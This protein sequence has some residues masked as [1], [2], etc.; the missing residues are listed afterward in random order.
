MTLS[1]ICM[2]LPIK[3]NLDESETLRLFPDGVAALGFG[4]LSL[5]RDGLHINVKWNPAVYNII[6]CGR[7][8]FRCGEITNLLVKL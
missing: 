3:K 8:C 5:D 6:L 2:L 1:I 4:T 7:L